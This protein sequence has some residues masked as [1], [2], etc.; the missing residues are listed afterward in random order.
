MIGLTD[1]HV[2]LPEVTV[3]HQSRYAAI[4]NHVLGS[5]SHIVGC[6]SSDLVHVGVA[7]ERVH[8]TDMNN[9]CGMSHDLMTDVPYSLTGKRKS[10]DSVDD[11]A[12]Y[13]KFD[14]QGGHDDS[15]LSLNC[16][17]THDSVPTM[18]ITTMDHSQLSLSG[19]RYPQRDNLPVDHSIF[20]H[21][22]GMPLGAPI[23]THMGGDGAEGGRASKK[24]RTIQ[25]R[26][27]APKPD[28]IPWE[29]W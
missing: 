13:E 11:D 12:I 15:S 5:D 29:E 2:T 17:V 3:L 21:P 26:L 16:G 10:Q 20:D 19:I 24:T 22:I 27:R 25:P 7:D 28:S 14:R 1:R 18:T 23:G 6:P 9:E 8:V 4:M